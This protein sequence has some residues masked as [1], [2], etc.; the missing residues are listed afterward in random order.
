MFHLYTPWKHKKT[1]GFLIFSGGVKM[2]NCPKMVQLISKFDYAFFV[3]SILWLK[4]TVAKLAENSTHLVI[5]FSN[6]M[7]S[8]ALIELTICQKRFILQDRQVLEF[9]FNTI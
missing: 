5:L 2:K 8:T 1:S 6:K 7:L 4:Q 3:Y 9:E